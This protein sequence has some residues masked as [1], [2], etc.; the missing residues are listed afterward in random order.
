VNA[1]R[2]TTKTDSTFDL[3]VNDSAT[4]AGGNNNTLPGTSRTH[5]FFIRA[6]DN[7][8]KLDPN[9]IIWNKRI[10][11]ATTSRPTVHFKP[12]YPGPGPGLDSLCD[13]TPF[14][15]CW[16]GSD[17]DGSILGY[18]FDVGSYSSPIVQDS[19]VSFNDP[20]NPKSIALSSGL[21]TLTV[22]SVDNAYALSDPGSSKF[23]FIVNRDPETWFT[24]ADG[25][26]PVGTEQPIGYY[27]SPYKLGQPDT[28]TVRTFAPGDTVPFRSTVWW[29][30]SGRD[31]PCDNPS[32][33]DAFS[34]SGQV[35]H[36]D[37]NP[38]IIGLLPEISPGVPFTTNDPGVLG[39]A[40]QSNLIL[41]SLD[42][43]ANILMR[44][45]AR[46]L[47]GRISGF[48]YSGE[49][50]FNCNFPPHLNGFQVSDS[51][52]LGR[53]NKYFTWTATDDEDGFPPGANLSLDNGLL[54]ITVANGKGSA[55]IP[56]KT[57]RDFSALN[58]HVAEVEVLDRAG[59][60]SPERLRVTFDVGPVDTC[61]VP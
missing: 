35:Y 47:S 33:I 30:W 15:V 10:I 20:S 4:I 61:V 51:C 13:G 7:L 46:D 6:V 38:Y 22:Q 49:F 19:C 58:P 55:L 24:K 52:Y 2:F 8:G 23:L 11:N 12:P 16:S 40:G 48:Q 56:F 18:K 59:Y 57:F 28:P 39:P 17:A 26:R 5:T 42:A 27:I 9:L 31:N 50:T 41:D 1:F 29:N 37:N 54:T 36:N 25:T 14:E 53:W 21:Y 60:K 45:R 43:G 44:V 34:L 32:G 3:A